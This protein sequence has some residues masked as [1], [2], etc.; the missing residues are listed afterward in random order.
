MYPLPKEP[1]KIKDRIRRYE[2]GLQ[3]EHRRFGAYDDGSGKR[4]LLGPLYMMV[5]D[6]PG[7]LKS[8]EWFA[9]NFSDDI[10]DPMHY[11][12]WTLAL[13]RSGDLE[14]AT[15][16]LR[17]T[18]L[19]NLYLV[20]HLLGLEQ[21]QLDIWHASNLDRKDYIE[22]TPPEIFE[23]WDEEALQWA[24]EAYQSPTLRQV[25]ERYIE[26]YRQLK[27]EPRGPKRSELVQE[28]SRLRGAER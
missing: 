16:K 2:R 26:I 8:F 28:A 14:A 23:L 25:R 18:M 6:L 13:Y 19:L 4:Y 15:H 24:R 17:Q 9:Q 10:G 7:A 11:L 22:Y 3:Q 27:T 1:K 12:C 20:P 5:D 21:A